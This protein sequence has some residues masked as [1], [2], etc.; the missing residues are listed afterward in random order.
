[1]S[2]DPSWIQ[3]ASL[4]SSGA[5][6]VTAIAAVIAF[7]FLRHQ[8]SQIERQIRGTTSRF[9]YEEMSRLLCV[10]IERPEL[11]PY[12]YE[13]KTLDSTLDPLDHQRVLAVAG[14]YADF[15]EQLLYQHNFGNLS[16]AEYTATWVT[17]STAVLGQSP[18]ICQHV[19][20]NPKY[21]S[22][23]FVEYVESVGV[24]PS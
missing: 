12:I 2:T 20:S 24:A 10:F 16:S 13:G 21:Y 4:A 19:S 9:M 6:V 7:S 18:V 22:R 8:Q 3:W 15:F 5:A 17:F 23:D 14:L 1:M 11:R